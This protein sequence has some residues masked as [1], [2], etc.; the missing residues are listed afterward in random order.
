MLRKKWLWAIVG[1]L[2]IGGTAAAVIS[3]RQDKGITVTA[4]TIQ[5]RDL[6]AIV[7]ASGKIEPQR[8]VNISAQSMGRVTR[9]AVN[10]GDRVKAGQFLLQ[11]DAVTAE[12]AVRRDEAAVAGARTALEQSRV[13]LQSARANL[14]LARQSLKRQQELSEAGLTTRETL[15]RAQAEVEIRES[16]LRAREQEIKNRET[17]LRQ[18]EAG[19][20]SSKH[21][22]AQVRF[23]APFDGIVTRR[24]IEEGE[25]V[26]VGTMNNAGTVLLTVA[27]MSVIEAEIEVDETDIPFVQ[28]DQLA[29]IT[30]DAIP[31]KSF[32]GKVTEIGNSPIQA[33]ATGST[34]RTATNFKVTVT[35]TEQ[36]P[37]VRPGFTCTAEI[38]TA[39]RSQALSVPIQ[40]LTVRELLY[41][42]SGTIIPE[43]RPPRQGFRF[44][45][46]SPPAP[47]TPVTREL[48]PGQ[49]REETEGVFVIRD[50]QAHFA[51]VKLGIAGERYLEVLAGLEQGDRVITGPFE[52]VRGMFE[53]DAVT[54]ASTS[55]PGL[56]AADAGSPSVRVRVGG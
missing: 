9:L 51:P 12:A 22:L 28:F 17:Q 18:Q 29:K 13:S 30:I 11:I 10:E 21:S 38:T 47:V 31:D 34:A 35:I 46:G 20:V 19:L 26:V 56:A 5:R 48:Q 23:E 37:D 32:T 40:A 27:N 41:D 44:S 3:R 50:G 49:K 39:T 52:S 6:E 54:T 7:S 53:G 15:E 4:E 33:T 45:F 8:T 55:A 42:Q 36:I 2:V 43:M 16:D 14:D 24:N 25:N 1:L